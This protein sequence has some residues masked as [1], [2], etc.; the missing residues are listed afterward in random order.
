MKEYDLIVIGSGAGL[1]VVENAVQHGLN[2]ALVDKGPLGGTCLNVGCIPSKI[3]IYPAD[4]VMEIRE[5]KKLGITAEVKGVDF[6]AV[7]ER[8]RRIVRNGEKH[9]R[10]G[11][12]YSEGLDFYEGE[13][14]FVMNRTLEVKG[15]KIRGKKIVIA[16]GARPFIPPVKGIDTIDF[17]TNETVLQLDKKPE[18][19]VIIG[20][21]YI[22]TE[23]AHF[24][25]ST[26]VKVTILQRNPRLL[27]E[28]EPEISALLKKKMGRRMQI[29]TGAEATGVKKA[30]S[31]ITVAAREKS[32]GRRL[33]FQSEGIM[34]GTG[35]TSN[36]DLLRVENTGI[37]TDER[38]YIKV[39]QYLETSQKNIWAFGDAIGKKMFRHVANKEAS[40]VWHNAV[41][42][43]KEGIDYLAAPHAVFA[44]PEIASV[45]LTE[46]QARKMY[47]ARD[48]LI[49]KAMYSD[50]ARG[51][52]MMEEEGFAKAIVKKDTKKILGFHIIG[53]H[54]S[55]LIQ[56]VVN[57]MANN[58]DIW[59]IARGMHIHP[60]L[61]ELIIAALGHLEEPE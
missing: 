59:S 10:D 39:N 42:N 16:T 33:T 31:C 30:G 2:V 45:G 7:M 41:H 5:S 46:E 48:I 21:G 32:S 51:N 34:V 36:A 43:A 54:A 55:L 61:P 25:D 26:G 52:A 13:A 38:N 58:G 35:R 4:M 24:F 12:K 8:M 1:I 18:S 17:L 28:E 9:V 49:G 6:G 22:A 19:I 47:H 23:Y 11:I 57:T 56:E 50:V 60:A 14:H 40:V 29:Y 15:E 20:G 44:Y 37:K 27:P 53:A 3:L